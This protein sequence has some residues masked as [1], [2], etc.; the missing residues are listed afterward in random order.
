MIYDNNL[1]NN[2]SPVIY[3]HIAYRKKG[4]FGGNDILSVLP[5]FPMFTIARKP[6][7]KH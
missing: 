7:R 4:S 2:S 1:A 6:F 5:I 3:R